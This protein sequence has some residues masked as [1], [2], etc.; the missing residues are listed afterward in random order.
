VEIVAFASLVLLNVIALQFPKRFDLTRDKQYTLAAATKETLDKLEAPVKVTAYFSK[1]LPPP[2]SQHARYTMDL[3]E[4]F[5]AASHGQLSF[6]LVDPQ[7]QETEEDKEKKREIKR[8]IFGRAVR[9][10]TS[11]EQELEGLGIQPVEVREFK[12]DQAQTRRAYM[13]IAVRYGEEKEAIPV[14]QDTSTLE[15][16]LTS[17]IRRLVRTKLPVIGVVQ[18]HGEPSLHEGLQK[19]DT[20]LKQNYELRAVNLSSPIGDDIDALLIVGPQQGFTPDEKN[21]IDAYLM[22]GKAAG[23]F[24]D[25]FQ[26]DLKTFQPTPNEQNLD[27][28]VGAYGVELGSQ[29]VGDVDC[30][31][32][33][34]QERRG[35]MIITMPLKYPFIPQP[36]ALEGSSPLTKGLGDVTLPFVAPLYPK[37]GMEGVEVQVLAKSSSKSWLEDG[38][39]ENLNP[40][41]DWAN[42]SIGFTGP[43][44]LVATARGALPSFADGSKKSAGEARVIVVGTSMFLNEQIFTQ[45]N[46]ALIFNMIDWLSLDAKLL[47]MRTRSFNDAPFK[48][49]LSDGAR[50]AAK[51]VNTAGVPALLVIFGLIRWRLREARRRQLAVVTP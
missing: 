23:F 31:S 44:N 46:A 33:N 22:K 16:D 42:A 34:V 45:Q 2:F 11:V 20:L 30:A 48:P 8:D 49:E 3:L 47:E 18:G 26:V 27:D 25:R 28:L 19:L 32:L 24:L 38:D 17:M 10:K 15:Y 5:H 9:E 51:V 35:F 14:V 40:R 50:N 7:E 6:E 41:R 13:G 36:R 43:Y 39:A 1:D 21:T 29:L 37:S 4:E 12:E